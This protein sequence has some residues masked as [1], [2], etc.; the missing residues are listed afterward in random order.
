M[1]R[2]NIRTLAKLEELNNQI[3]KLYEKKREIVCKLVE[4]YGANEFLYELDAPTEEGCKFVR[5]K[6]V[7]N[8]EAFE[9]GKPLFKASAFERFAYECKYLKNRPKE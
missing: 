2:P 7:D 3:N 4:K 6:L 8:L 1:S 9:S 5:Y